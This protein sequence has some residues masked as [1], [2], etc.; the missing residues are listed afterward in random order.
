M[1]PA[2][3]SAVFGKVIINVHEQLTNQDNQQLV[4]YVVH[5]LMLCHKSV[6]IPYIK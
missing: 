6:H 3:L 1:Q 2:Q 4:M 5:E